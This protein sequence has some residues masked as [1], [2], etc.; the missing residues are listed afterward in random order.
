MILIARH[1]TLALFAAPAMVNQRNKTKKAKN[2]N[3]PTSTLSTNAKNGSSARKGPSPVLIPKLWLHG[4]HAVSPVDKLV[5]DHG[6][7]H[8]KIMPPLSVPPHD[9]AEAKKAM[10]KL[11]GMPRQQLAQSSTSGA[12]ARSS[13]VE[14]LERK[15]HK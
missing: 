4:P 11:L 1:T 14:V 9:I 5:S 2:N 10:S 8:T 7:I 12:S 15:K 3:K 13:S 6:S